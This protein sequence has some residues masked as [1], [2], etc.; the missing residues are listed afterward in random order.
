M[1]KSADIGSVTWHR[2][3]QAA[4][5]R[6]MP[7]NQTQGPLLEIAERLVFFAVNFSTDR[8]DVTVVSE[9]VAN[10]PAVGSRPPAFLG[11]GPPIVSTDLRKSEKDVGEKDDEDPGITDGKMECTSIWMSKL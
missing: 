2:L 9:S 7:S 1:A 8:L 5:K 3:H 10:V 11:S 4:R 6:A